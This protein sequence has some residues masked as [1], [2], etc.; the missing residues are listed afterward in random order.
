MDSGLHSIKRI[1]KLLILFLCVSQAL[2]AQQKIT[3]ITNQSQFDAAMVQINNGEEMHMEL[4]KGKYKLNH[5]VRATA[6]L[7]IKGRNA[8]IT[9]SSG[10]LKPR[11]CIRKTKTHNIYRLDR[12]LSLFPLFYDGRGEILS[13]SESVRDGCGVNYVDGRIEGP[14]DYEP[15]VKIKIPI[16]YNLAHLKN[17][18]FDCVFGYFDSGWSVVNFSVEK[19]DDKFFY[20]TTLNKCYTNDFQYDS[21][22]Y[23]KPVRYVIYNAELLPDMVY[24]DREFLY[25][26]KSVKEVY[27]LNN[28]DEEH[29]IPEI[30]TY[31][32]VEISG[33]SFVGIAGLYVKSPLKAKCHIHHCRFNNSLGQTLSIDKTNGEGV[34]VA[35][36]HDCVFTNCSLYSDNIIQLYSTFE[37]DPCIEIENN[38]IARYPDS[39]VRNKNTQGAV[40]VNG[41][42]SITNNIIYNT[43]RDHLFLRRGKN[44]V[45]GNFLFNTD[46]F[47][48]KIDRNLSSDWG[49]IYSGAITR[50]SEEAQ[51]NKD[52]FI[53]VEGNLLYGAYAYGEDARG[54]FLDTGRGDVT[55][56]DNIILNTQCYSLD[57]R[58]VA[59]VEASSIRNRYE[60]NVLASNYR[61]QSGKDVKGTD[62]PCTTENVLLTKDDNHISEV[63]VN[64]EDA[65]LD[66]IDVSTSLNNMNRLQVSKELYYVIR[67]SSAWKM[68]KRYVRKSR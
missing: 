66:G 22:V 42:A 58:Y 12:E 57:S 28:P 67:K 4:R 14:D 24:F 43:C 36:V 47:N 37:G 20:C 9:C 68:V 26:P 6:P 10:P 16:A 60:N 35:R 59:T 50:N 41:D 5:S 64:M 2:F 63:K 53:L 19:S 13:L 1:M 31:S 45:K 8:I 7:T 65:R 11:D 15:G 23:K 30:R 40:W 38:I 34:A 17:R 21:M 49:L 33:V 27:V 3:F 51:K 52:H 62:S 32:D 46:E 44:I 61:L 56:K 55:C 54:V 18:A 39:K 29:K 48:S 25:V